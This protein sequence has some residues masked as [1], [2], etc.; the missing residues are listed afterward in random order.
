MTKPKTPPPVVVPQLRG[1]SHKLTLGQIWFAVWR[2]A[3]D[4]HRYP[5]ER[6]ELAD[7]LG[8][9]LRTTYDWEQNPEILAAIRVV[10]RRFGEAEYGRVL[11]S[12]AREAI[13]GSDRHARLYFELM[14]DLGQEAI[15]AAY[16]KGAASVT[17]IGT[18]QVLGDASF[19][20]RRIEVSSELAN[21]IAAAGDGRDGH[22]G[23]GG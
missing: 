23:G 21:R 10:G 12:V 22:D 9:G 1:G 6:Q 20:Q 14:G 4:D 16:N 7:R 17:Q 13:A 5:T 3:P 18:V 11:A 15:D 2:A 19:D 8:V